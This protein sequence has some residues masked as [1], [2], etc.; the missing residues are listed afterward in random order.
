ML[1]S[2]LAL[3]YPGWPS[4]EHRCGCCI[5]S[6]P[7]TRP[8]SPHLLPS[9]QHAVFQGFASSEGKGGCPAHSHHP[10]RGP[11]LRVISEV[12]HSEPLR[13]GHGGLRREKKCRLFMDYVSKR[14]AKVDPELLLRLK[15]GVIMDVDCAVL[16]L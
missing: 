2:P 16:C 12:L 7:L 14:V 13:S 1:E 6:L 8:S 5:F 11:E 4:T 3:W 10:E 15:H 9:S